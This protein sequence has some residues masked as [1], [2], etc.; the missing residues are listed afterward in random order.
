MRVGWVVGGGLIIDRQHCCPQQGRDRQGSGVGWIGFG[1]HRQTI[2]T[3][4]LNK[5]EVG[6]GLG[7]AGLG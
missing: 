1:T 7:F 6:K 5:A 4:A 3:V 2:R